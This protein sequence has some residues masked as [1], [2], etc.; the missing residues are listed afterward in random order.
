VF[1]LRIDEITTVGCIPVTTVA[2]TLLDLAFIL[3]HADIERAVEQA[4]SKRLTTRADVLSVLNQHARTPGAARLRSLIASDEPAFTRSE[5][6]A[7]LL[8]LIRKARLARP[9]VNVMVAGY[10][11]DFFWRSQRFIA[12]MDGC[13]YHSSHRKFE[14]DRRRDAVLTVAG[15]RV[16]R[17]T[18]QQLA[19]ESEA[20]IAT[21]AQALGS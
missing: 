4:L 12:E 9:E 2:R 16:I 11:V 1:T 13:A 21:L 6:E 18:W 15:I 10:E 3:P 5:A 17:V 8:T 14:S 20:L 19:N 7:R